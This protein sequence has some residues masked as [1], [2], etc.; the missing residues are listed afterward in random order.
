[1]SCLRCQK[2]AD[3][4][5][6][7]SCYSTLRRW[8]YA[9]CRPGLRPR[10]SRKKIA[11]LKLWVLLL[12]NY[13][14]E[15]TPKFYMFQHITASIMKGLV[16]FYYINCKCKVDRIVSFLFNFASFTPSHYYQFEAFIFQLITYAKGIL[17]AVKML[18]AQI[19]TEL[20][21]ATV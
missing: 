19:Q 18:I 17:L 20:Q 16:L 7:F 11:G 4:E 10:L 14:G 9:K 2:F 15:C 3:L 13:A 6:R 8:V 21:F 12:I 1:M 5:T